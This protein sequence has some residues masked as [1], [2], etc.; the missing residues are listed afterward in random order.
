MNDAAW[1]ALLEAAQD[2]P[3]PT[4][5]LVT[6]IHRVLSLHVV[7]LRLR[8]VQPRIDTQVALLDEEDG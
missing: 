3:H 5:A 8:R 6:A 4:R 2:Q 1:H 7:Q